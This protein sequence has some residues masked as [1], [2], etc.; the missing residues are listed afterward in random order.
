[1]RQP[2]SPGHD[3]R[4]LRCLPARSA[5]GRRRDRRATGSRCRVPAGL[6]RRTSPPAP[7]SW[8]ASP[9]SY[10]ARCRSP[11]RPAH[12]A[13][14]RAGR[15]RGR[16][17]DRLPRCP[18]RLEVDRRIAGDLD[19]VEAM[20]EKQIVGAARA[21]WPSSTRTRWP[22]AAGAPRPTEVTTK[23]APDT[24]MW[25]TSLM[26]VKDGVAVWAVLSREADPS[27]PPATRARA[28][29]SWP[30]RCATACSRPASSV[31]SASALMINVIVP[32]SRAP[33]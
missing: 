29:R 10:A 17:G 6:A 4:G 13:D 14:D 26:P 32:D 3:R 16:A 7:S 27:A 2:G 19:A 30:T 28:T 12:G 25:L 1:M 8:S 18:E 11:T 20:S 21:Q 23:P 15:D 9:R 24:M 31:A 33:R 5:A 22:S